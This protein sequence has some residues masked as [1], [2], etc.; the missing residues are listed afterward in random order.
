MNPLRRSPAYLCYAAALR[1]LGSAYALADALLP[2]R[3]GIRWLR[4]HWRAAFH[5]LDLHALNFEETAWGHLLFRDL[6]AY[7]SSL[8]FNSDG[9][10]LHEQ[11]VPLCRPYN[12]LT[13]A[14]FALVLWNRHL[15]SGEECLLEKMACQLEF[16]KG[17]AVSEGEALLLQYPFDEPKFAMKAPWT[18]AIAQAVAAMA[19]LRLGL[20]RNPERWRTFARRLLRGMLLPQAAGGTRIVLPD[21]LP[22][23]EEY[24]SPRPSLV[25]NGY[26]FALQALLE[27][28][29]LGLRPLPED[30]LQQLW[31]SLFQRL[32]DFVRGRQLK[33]CQSLP[34]LCGLHYRLLQILQLVQLGRTSGQQSLVGLGKDL[35]AKFPW[36]LYARFYGGEGLEALRERVM[37]AQCSTDA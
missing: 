12:P 33:Y 17:I 37:A 13:S 22:W 5:P 34:R 20:R 4:K 25:L 11:A 6:E 8:V 32:P 24:P 29:A 2:H 7:E 36:K 14:N 15:L 3:P 21:G 31:K 9:V 27:G 18:S 19:A 35:T 1:L 26:L 23:L 10:A 30:L 16:L 28:W